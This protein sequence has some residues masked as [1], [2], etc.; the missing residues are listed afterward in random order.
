MLNLRKK[1]LALALAAAVVGGGI[2]AVQATVRNPDGLGQVQIY[3][4]FTV[5]N[6]W[7]TFIHVT[8][9]GDN[10][11]AAKVRFHEAKTSRDVLDFIVVLSPR[12]MWTAVVEADASGKPGV[13]PT[14]NTCTVPQIGSGVWKAFYD[15]TATEG[16]VEIIGMGSSNLEDSTGSV[17]YYAQHNLEG[18]NA[19]IPR[20]CLMVEQAFGPSK[21][22]DTDNEFFG[23][24]YTDKDVLTGKFDLINVE[25]GWA[26]ASR[27]VALARFSAPYH[28][29]MR[30]PQVA[31]QLGEFPNLDSAWSSAFDWHIRGVF[32]VNLALN[33]T[34]II[35]EWVLNP[36][37]EEKS[38]WVVTFPTQALTVNAITNINAAKTAAKVTPL[39]SNNFSGPQPIG[40]RLCNREELCKE[41]AFSGGATNVLANEVNVI[42]FVD[43]SKGIS[44]A[45]ILGS[46]VSK[47]ID[48]A[49]LKSPFLGGWLELFLPANSVIAEKTLGHQAFE[50]DFPGEG[51]GHS[52]TTPT[53]DYPFGNLFRIDYPTDDPV[54]D[55]ALINELVGRPVV[56]FNITQRSLPT[57]NASLY[58]HAYRGTFSYLIGTTGDGNLRVAPE[59]GDEL[60]G[61]SD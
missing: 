53:G 52:Y 61:G 46:S 21:I 6:G 27:A 25:A 56:G 11:V 10:T 40:L 50:R 44:A 4:Y 34:S 54:G 43:T 57:E 32:A 41:V 28:D 49:D 1:T 18:A 19:G 12:D 47:T 51:M 14:D 59:K 16:Y 37:L 45:N 30:F 15:S 8:N 23:G 13:R 39:L 33:A 9:T 42:D 22:Q 35:N 17:A 38:S 48:T 2:S 29:F 58:E 31:G 36:G 3:P 55:A 24:D 7:R 5:K 26:G 20:S 60:E